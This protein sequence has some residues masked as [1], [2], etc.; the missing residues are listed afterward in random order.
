MPSSRESSQRNDRTC[1]SCVSCIAD[2]WATRGIPMLPYSLLKFECTATL[3]PHFLILV[4]YLYVIT[5]M[6]IVQ[7]IQKSEHFTISHN[8]FVVVVEFYSCN[9]MLYNLGQGTFILNDTLS[10]SFFFS[11]K[12]PTFNW[13]VANI[14]LILTILLGELLYTS[15]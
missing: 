13:D 12:N 4:S 7:N 11:L 2:H 9:K 15:M 5:F 3:F 6:Y 10:P 14:K 8:N 1:L